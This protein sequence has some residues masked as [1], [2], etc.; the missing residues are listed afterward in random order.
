MRIIARSTLREFWQKYPDS[1]QSLKAWFYDVKSANWQSPSDI[2]NVYANASIIANNR[3]VFNIRG[4]R[5]RLIVHVRYDIGI[6]F[7]RFIGT[8]QD[9][10]QID[11]TTI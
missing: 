7:I 4:N 11:S 1:E 3:V 6:V 2:K 10:D 8:H 5:Y 9:Y